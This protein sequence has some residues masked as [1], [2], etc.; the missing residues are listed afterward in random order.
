MMVVRLVNF[1]WRGE[2]SLRIWWNVMLFEKGLPK[3]WRF[4]K[5]LKINLPTESNHVS[6]ENVKTTLL[7]KRTFPVKQNWKM[8]E[9]SFMFLFKEL[10][11]PEIYRQFSTIQQ[12]IIFIESIARCGKGNTQENIQENIQQ[13]IQKKIFWN[14]TDTIF[15][16]VADERFDRNLVTRFLFIKMF[17]GS[18]TKTSQNT[19]RLVWNSEAWHWPRQLIL[20]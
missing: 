13:N 17:L 16:N 9:M 8:K 12:N 3:T 6:F 10:Y 4:I 11:F 18:H 2:D 15:C 19:S 20:I 1:F 14:I 5:P 7:D